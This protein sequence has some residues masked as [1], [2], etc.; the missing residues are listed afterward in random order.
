MTTAV[1]RW[2]PSVQEILEVAGAAIADLT[3][4][5]VIRAPAS[6]DVFLEGGSK[7][8]QTRRFF[9]GRQPLNGI[10]V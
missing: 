7:P 8:A 9:G 10:A 1:D 6:G 3:V 4:G 5:S 2:V